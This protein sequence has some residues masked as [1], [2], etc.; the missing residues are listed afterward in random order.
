[1]KNVYSGR[2]EAKAAYRERDC[3]LSSK[4]FVKQY[5]ESFEA[6]PVMKLAAD[7]QKQEDQ[8]LR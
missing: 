2:A 4:Y 8:T 3:V 6:D 7:F 5:M 1:M